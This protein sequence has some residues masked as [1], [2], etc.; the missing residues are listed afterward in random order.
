MFV[1]LK[2]ILKCGII[3]VLI[4]QSTSKSEL[5]WKLVPW[6]RTFGFLIFSQ[7][8]LYAY[9]EELFVDCLDN[10]VLKSFELS[11]LSCCCCFACLTFFAIY[12][13]EVG[14]ILLVKLLLFFIYCFIIYLFIAFLRNFEWRYLSLYGVDTNVVHSL[15]KKMYVIFSRN[16]SLEVFWQKLI[17]NS[18][19]EPSWVFRNIVRMTL[20]HQTSGSASPLVFMGWLPVIDA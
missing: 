11:V 3:P 6:M 15:K 18:S 13:W 19:F 4:Q 10:Q 8:F 16:I 9:R 12:I 20:L 14:N 17:L 2:F 7:S 5:N 1:H